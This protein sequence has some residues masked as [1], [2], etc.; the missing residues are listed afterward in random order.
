MTSSSAPGRARP[1]HFV[2]YTVMALIAV[3]LACAGYFAFGGQQSAPNAT[4]T[5]LSGQKV[6]TSEL[7]GKVYMV[8]FWATSCD[9]CIKE[10][11]QMVET[12]NRFKDRGLE[13]VAVAMSYD[14]PAYVNNYA[15]TRQLPFKVAMDDGSAASQFGNVQLT[16]TT[17]VID[18]N[19]K[20][21]KRYVGAPQ[22]T[23]LDQLL[24]KALKAA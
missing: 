16:P 8:N 13:F 24:D 12:Y 3:A 6:S 23:E 4:F 1:H 21:L 18:K 11:P 7:K 14:T 10:M 9:T 19:G 22:F 2:R 15:T 20:I 17:F 5:L